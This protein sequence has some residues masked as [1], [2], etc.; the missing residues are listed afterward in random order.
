MNL[1][2]VPIQNEIQISDSNNCSIEKPKLKRAKLVAKIDN[3]VAISY[4][5]YINK[6]IQLNKFKIPELKVAAKSFKLPVSG[7][8][9]ALIER[10]ETYFLKQKNSTIIQ[11]CYRRRL[12]LL[13]IRLRGSALKNRSTCLNDTDFVTME[14]LD[15][16]PTEYFC[17]YSDKGSF[18]YGF[19][20]AS[21]AQHLLKQKKPL[22][23]Y[24]REKINSSTVTNIFKLY[25]ITCILYPEFK[26]END[27]IILIMPIPH[28]VPS[29]RRS[30]RH[31]TY[32]T[33]PVTPSAPLTNTISTTP[34]V[35]PESQARFDRI[36]EVRTHP[37]DYRVQA[38]F[39]EI[40][41]L[42]NY[43]Q[44]AWFSNL[45][46]RQL[47][48][49]YRAMYEIW[50]YR[51]Q[52]PPLVRGRISPFCNPFNDV[53]PDTL[54]H[55]GYT[56][57]QLKNLCLIVFENMVYSGIDEDHRKLGTFHALSAL[58]IVSNEARIAMPWLYES[59]T[60]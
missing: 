54:F 59:V 36:Q 20:L 6:S 45:D 30:T 28:R 2:E 55:A 58:T 42:G 1:I 50:Y 57:D 14:R 25:R 13:S 33:G 7:T 39:M 47:V 31:T 32:F 15:E 23:P 4:E 60:Y 29:V 22:N 27:S 43:T 34:I 48:R 12:A 18:T 26:K 5:N 53:Y 38:L 24:N 52:I 51:G 11:K 37:I 21:I 35:E 46:G 16:I 49:F 17:S 8:K 10:L 44:S 3:A 19:N 41:Q 9:P 56:I 40:D